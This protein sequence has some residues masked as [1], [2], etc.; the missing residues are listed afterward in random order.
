MAVCRQQRLNMPTAGN[1]HRRINSL[2]G[3]PLQIFIAE[4]FAELLTLFAYLKEL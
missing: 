2:I 4:N 3:D 1:I